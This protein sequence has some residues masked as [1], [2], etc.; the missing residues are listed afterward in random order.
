MDG[1][2]TAR[3][4]TIGVQV[5]PLVKATRGT[6]FY[7]VT[8]VVKPLI[9]AGDLASKNVICLTPQRLR[10]HNS[11]KL[12]EMGNPVGVDRITSRQRPIQQLTQL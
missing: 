12:R 2:H 11:Q 3:V 4:T 7:T 10:L 1:R 5:C 8:P 6:P 9:Y